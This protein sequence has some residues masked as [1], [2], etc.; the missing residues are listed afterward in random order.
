LSSPRP[1][2]PILDSRL[3]ANNLSEPKRLALEKQPLGYQ[4]VENLF[5]CLLSAA[6]DIIRALH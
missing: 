1:F 4:S 2:R 6:A 3:L 5:Q